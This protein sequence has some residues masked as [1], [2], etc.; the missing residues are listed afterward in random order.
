MRKRLLS[1]ILVLLWIGCSSHKSTV[2]EAP[3]TGKPKLMLSAAPRQGFAPLRVTFHA[4]LEGVAEN[5]EEFYC[6]KE[7]WDFGDG[8]VSSETPNCDPYSPETRITI[9]FFTEHLFEDPGSYSASFTLGDKKLRS[10]R[11]SITALESTRG[12]SARR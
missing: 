7:E 5:S 11:I 3:E 1:F 6:L 12:S 10:A 4:T 9:E 2:G 8:A